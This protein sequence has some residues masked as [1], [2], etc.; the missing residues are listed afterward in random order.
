MQ[1]QVAVCGPSDCTVAEADHAFRVGQLLAERGAI[2]LCGGGSGVMDAVAAGARSH[3]GLV[4]GI[5]PDA[6]KSTASPH[7]S[8]VVLTNLGEARNAVI[9]SSADAV[10]V[11]GGS[12]G[13]LSEAALAKR[14]GTVPVI[15]LGGWRIADSAGS[16]VEG[17][18]EAAT[19]DEAVDLALAQSL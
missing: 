11:I 14:R 8:A 9:I 17:I 2:V 7:L 19:P 4:I 6:D 3:D 13:T 1:T 16:P 18:R 10:I 5:R 15:S 12:W